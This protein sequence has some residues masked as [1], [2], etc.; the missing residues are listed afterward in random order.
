MSLRAGRIVKS[1]LSAVLI[2]LTCLLVPVSLLTVWVHDIV[3]DNDRYVA[4]VA[5]LASDPAI[6]EAAVRRISDA[7]DVRVD[8]AR[9]TADLA[10][11]LEAQGLPP[12]VGAAVKALGPGLDSA[13]DQAVSKV[14]TRFVESDRF[15]SLW[16]GANRAAHTAVVHALTARGRGAVG[17]DGG[18]SP[19]TSAAPWRTSRRSS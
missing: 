11:W 9:V 16:T 4:T 2:T 7:A 15:E 1:T 19:S 14:A 6:E 10:K 5:P 13:A 3:L 12:R 17:I 18:P 8:G